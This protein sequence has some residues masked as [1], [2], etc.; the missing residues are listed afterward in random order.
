MKDKHFT[1]EG[2]VSYQYLK[3]LSFDESLNAFRPS[4]DQF[5]A[6]L[7]IT[8]LPEGRIYIAREDKHIIGYVTYHYPDDFE[9]W[10]EGQ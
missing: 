4:N 5:E 1:I 9:R 7:E 6:L 10:A 2:P 3:T 8:Q